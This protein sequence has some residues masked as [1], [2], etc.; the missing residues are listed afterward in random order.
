MTADQQEEVEDMECDELL[1]FMD[2]LNPEKFMDDLEFKNLTATLKKKVDELQHDPDFM[3]RLHK[4][5]ARR[6]AAKLQRQEMAKQNLANRPQNYDDDDMFTNPGDGGR[7][8]V[9]SVGSEKTREAIQGLKEKQEAAKNGKSEWDNT[10]NGERKT[11]EDRISKHIADEILRTNMAF[12]KVHSNASVRK[13]LE[14]EVK[15]HVN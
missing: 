14:Q 5:I 9:H 8:E 1:D 12:A 15:K 10:T 7:G 3:E 13:M 4:D 6:K 11:F 2:N